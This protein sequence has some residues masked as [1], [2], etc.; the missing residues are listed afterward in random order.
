MKRKRRGELRESSKY[1]EHTEE[2]E[3]GEG[4][5]DRGVNKAA[6]REI[7]AG[8]P[9]GIQVVIFLNRDFLGTFRHCR[10]P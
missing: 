5:G 2:K 9:F 3:A 4:A 1:E 8:I 6:K 7:K 10:I